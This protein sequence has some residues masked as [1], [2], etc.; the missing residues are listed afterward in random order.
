MNSLNISSNAMQIYTE[1][2]L[3]SIV[4][5]LRIFLDS[6]FQWIAAG[7]SESG[8][9]DTLPVAMICTK[10]I[11]AILQSSINLLSQFEIQLSETVSQESIINVLQ[12]VAVEAI[13]LENQPKDKDMVISNQGIESLRVVSMGILRQVS[14]RPYLLV[15]HRFSQVIRINEVL[16]SMKSYQVL[17]NFLPTVNKLDISD[18]WMDD[19]FNLS[20]H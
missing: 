16:F 19:L 8:A 5:V 9:S 4:E 17:P 12:F 6:V 18:S 7:M 20:A 3:K 13:F 11:S 10:Q 15:D 1:E 2:T 14:L